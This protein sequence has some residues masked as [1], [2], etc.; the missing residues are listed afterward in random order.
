METLRVYLENMF[1]SL[2]KSQQV[3]DAK[4]ELFAMMEDK[5]RELLEE[6]K[7][8]HEATG[9]VISEFGNLEEVAESLGIRPEIPNPSGARVLKR[10]EV[11][12]I[13]DCAAINAKKFSEGT[14]LVFFGV[15]ILLL[16]LAFSKS[17]FEYYEEKFG[18][19]GVF[20]LLGCVSLSVHRF[21]SGGMGAEKLKFLE[22][23]SPALSFCDK[24]WLRQE[25]D[26][27]GL[28][29]KIT[30]SATLSMLSCAIVP[31][32]LLFF[33]DSEGLILCAVAMMLLVMGTALGVLLRGVLEH[34]IY[35]KLIGEGEY[36]PEKR[37]GRQKVHRVSGLFWSAVLLIYFMVSLF[38]KEWGRTAMVF[39]PAGMIYIGLVNYL[40][41]RDE[42]NGR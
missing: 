19:V 1:Q 4:E 24:I 32:I 14:F 10:E 26:S 35:E 2:P 36:S 31:V 40:S 29:K 39:F 11:E 21:V 16:G 38:M 7:G 22:E 3:L 20:L 12:Q 9:I 6:G 28:P 18:L 5:Y 15:F 37:E 41:C 30:L 13:L 33:E 23:E 42:R 25:R 27:L 34:R 17:P 8:V